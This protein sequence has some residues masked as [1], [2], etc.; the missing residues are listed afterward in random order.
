MPILDEGKRHQGLTT[1]R[2]LDERA[3][4]FGRLSSPADPEVEYV[5]APSEG[6]FHF[7]VE[8]LA[9]LAHRVFPRWDW[10]RRPSIY[11]QRQRHIR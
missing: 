3:H 9:F 10:R 1:Q 11:V 6:L 7:A 2:R 4:E 5:P 8:P